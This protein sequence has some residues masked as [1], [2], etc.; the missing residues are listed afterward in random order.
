M[1]QDALQIGLAGV[2][3]MV[4]ASGLL[5][6]LAT[7]QKPAGATTDDPA[8]DLDDSGFPIP[9][10]DDVAGL[11]DIAC[12]APPFSFSDSSVA[13]KETKGMQ[14]LMA[15]APKHVLLDRRYPTAEDGWR[16][17]WRIVIDGTP[18]DL[19]GVEGDSQGQMTRCFVRR[20]TQ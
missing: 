9:S 18:Y 4:R 8:G 19:M 6:S 15:D 13:A 12:T 7:F 2:M 16:N 20:L 14:E 3:P 1:N 10:W 17:G 5:V 11:V